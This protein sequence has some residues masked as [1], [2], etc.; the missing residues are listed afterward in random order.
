MF[1]SRPHSS[2]FFIVFPWKVSRSADNLVSLPKTLKETSLFS[3]QFLQLGSVCKD[4]AE[5]FRRDAFGSGQ[6]SKS[7]FCNSQLTR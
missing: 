6:N 2:L 1:L 7:A 3:D 4:I 5:Q